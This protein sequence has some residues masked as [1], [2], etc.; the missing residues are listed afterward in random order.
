MT[1]ALQTQQRPETLQPRRFSLQEYHR[2]IDLGFFDETERIELIHGQLI[3]MAAKGSAHETCITRLLRLLPNAIGDQAT[4]RCQA[5]ITLSFDGEPEPDF[6]I[7]QNQDDDY[8]SGHPTETETLI[9][10]EVAKSSLDYDRDIKL[11]LYA[12]ANIS[13][14]WIFNL[15]DHHLETYS[16][17]SQLSPG[18]S[19][20]SQFG[21]LNRRIVPMDQEIALPGFPSSMISLSRAFPPQSS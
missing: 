9:V 14:Y 12:Q 8:A 10:I 7:V 6:S 21:Y 18:Q 11:P 19:S 16:E 15:I 13:H 2:L 17:P 20:P 3:P 4:L 1:V 5:P